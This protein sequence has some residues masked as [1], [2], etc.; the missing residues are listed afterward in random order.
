MCFVNPKPKVMKTYSLMGNSTQLYKI[1][2]LKD[3]IE[4]TINLLSQT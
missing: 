1:K 4:F 3:K 2:T